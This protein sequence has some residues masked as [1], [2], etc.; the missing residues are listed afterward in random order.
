MTYMR[1]F[2]ALS[3]IYWGL[4]GWAIS[5]PSSGAIMIS[6]GGLLLCFIGHRM[7]DRYLT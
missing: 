3:F 5:I 1:V 7:S 2:F 6:M 4:L